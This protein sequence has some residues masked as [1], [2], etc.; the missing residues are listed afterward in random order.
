MY[1]H[2]SKCLEDPQE[3]KRKYIA[4]NSGHVSGQHPH[5]GK[6]ALII[7][8][9]PILIKRALFD[10]VWQNATYRFCADGGA[11]RLFDLLK[12]DGERAKFLPDHIRGDMDSLRDD[13]KDYYCSQ[14]V[15]VERVGDQDS[16][17]F[18]KCVELVHARDPAVST[19]TT[20]TTT[21][22]TSST[23]TDE[24]SV[25]AIPSSTPS[26]GPDHRTQEERQATNFGIVALGGTGGRFDQS[27]SNIHHL[28]ILN[29]E[30]QATLVSNESIVVVLGAGT[31]EIT[32]NLD[33]EGSTCGI[34]PVGTS[35]AI[36]TTTGL[37]WD[38]EDWK[39]S[40]GGRIST[41]NA[42][43]DSKVTIKTTAP[44]VW[45]TELRP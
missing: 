30:R 29:Q 36:L 28:Y 34:I 41:S 38:V 35:E 17:D 12:T 25:P 7:L 21:T 11:N 4:A 26:E 13:V 8:N 31:H 33:I 44:V 27:M 43:V 2:P 37:K 19:T 42:L 22:T 14:G 45:T 1:W 3:Y 40:F 16:T 39:T 10:N 18:M 24:T 20:T 23:T 6:F 9:Q 5:H 15:P 32:C